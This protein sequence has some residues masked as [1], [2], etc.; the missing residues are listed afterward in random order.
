MFARRDPKPTT[1][2]SIERTVADH[3]GI[4]NTHSPRLSRHD[5]NI[6]LAR[7]VAM[8]IIRITTGASYGQIGRHFDR[9]AATV[10]NAHRRV[11]A[12]AE[13]NPRMRAT[14]DRICKDIR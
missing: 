13:Q 1:M 4:E 12:L 3:Y 8:H 6:T 7:H 10:L 11:E 2:R 5:P 14:L 9:D